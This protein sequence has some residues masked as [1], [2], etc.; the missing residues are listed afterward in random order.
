MAFAKNR[1]FCKLASSTSLVLTRTLLYSQILA[2]AS[3][4]IFFADSADEICTNYIKKGRVI[5]LGQ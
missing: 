1:Y 5:P 3:R 4:D 2:F